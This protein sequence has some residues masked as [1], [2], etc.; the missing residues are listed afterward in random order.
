MDNFSFL[1]I[2]EKIPETRFKNMG[3]FPSDKVPQVTKYSFA[4]IN[5][6]PSNDRGVHW[7]MIARLEKTYYFA[8][9]LGQK[10]TTNSFLTKRYWQTVLSKL[11][12]TDNLCGFYAIY[13]SFLLFKFYL[14]N[15][16]NNHDVHVFEFYN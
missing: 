3:S 1:Q 6:A 8:D 15:L 11:Q 9:S 7:I 2:I 5:S 14:R 12:K 16:N 4:I 10:S 13:S